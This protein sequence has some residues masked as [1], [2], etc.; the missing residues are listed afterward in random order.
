MVHIS[1][2]N[3]K[4]FFSVYIIF[5]HTLFDEC[6]SSIEVG[7]NFLTYE[8]TQTAQY[9]FSTQTDIFFPAQIQANS[10]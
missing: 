2:V 8:D 10:K 7:S 1:F 3:L 9:K 5:F 4:S 6:V